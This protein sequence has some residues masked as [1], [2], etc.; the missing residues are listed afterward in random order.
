LPM[1]PAL[2]EDAVRAVTAAVAD[3]LSQ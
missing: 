3:A 2:D 1:G